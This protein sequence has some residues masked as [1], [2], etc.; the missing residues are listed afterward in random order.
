[1]LHGHPVPSDGVL[2]PTLHDQHTDA[3]VRLRSA[4]HSRGSR[5]ISSWVMVH[6]IVA[7][8]SAITNSQTTCEYSGEGTM[9]PL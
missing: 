9:G 4:A 1:M 6:A 7:T 8:G 5:K 2:S 3:A